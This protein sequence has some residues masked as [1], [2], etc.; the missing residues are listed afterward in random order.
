MTIRIAM[1]VTAMVIPIVASPAVAQQ[2]QQ[3][4]QIQQT[5]PF[6]PLPPQQNRRARCDYQSCFDACLKRGGFTS[7]AH[8]NWH[9]GE[10]CQRRCNPTQ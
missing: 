3:G 1:I 2:E 9:C 5:Q 10:F 8:M 6:P 4:Q 7:S